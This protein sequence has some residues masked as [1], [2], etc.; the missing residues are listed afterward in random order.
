M[1][2]SFPCGFLVAVLPAFRRLVPA[3]M[4]APPMVDLLGRDAP[5]SRSRGL[6]GPARAL[7]GDP[8]L[9]QRREVPNITSLHVSK[10]PVPPADNASTV[11]GAATAEPR[12]PEGLVGLE[13]RVVDGQLFARL[14]PSP[15]QQAEGV[16][17][18]EVGVARVVE[19]IAF[20]GSPV[21]DAVQ[22]IVCLT[23]LPLARA[24]SARPR[25][26]V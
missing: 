15:R 10:L 1:L 8:F 9:Q 7:P 2:R 21:F 6:T 14:G 17:E 19:K 16:F 25:S 5:G 12:R 18:P 20:V 4:P 24:L 3:S 22:V 11:L 23:S 13:E 26:V